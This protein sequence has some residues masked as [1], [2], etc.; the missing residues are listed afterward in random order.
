MLYVASLKKHF[1][2]NWKVN[3]NAL[4]PP[5]STENG[6]WT[7][8]KKPLSCKALVRIFLFEVIN[9]SSLSHRLYFRLA[10]LHANNLKSAIIIYLPSKSVLLSFNIL[11][12]RSKVTY[13]FFSFFSKSNQITAATLMMPDT[14]I[15]SFRYFTHPCGSRIIFVIQAFC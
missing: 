9:L 3:F 11:S 5:F 1:D 13:S 8:Q 2:F 10:L 6:V 4:L 12:S 15:H 14:H 7:G